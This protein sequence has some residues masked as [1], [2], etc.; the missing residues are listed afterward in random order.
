[1]CGIAGY[2]VRPDVPWRPTH[3]H[4]GKLLEDN[5]TR[6][7]DAT[8]YS[9][10]LEGS[11][12]SGKPF[13][14]SKAPIRAT[15]FVSFMDKNQTKFPIGRMGVLHTRG[16]SVGSPKNN[17][18]NHPIVY[19][20][21]DRKVMIVHNGSVGNLTEAYSKLGVE[22]FAEVDS[23]LFAAA[24]AVLGPEGGL[25]FMVKNSGGSATVAAMFNDGTFLLA[26]SMN[27]LYVAQPCD[28]AIMF[29]SVISELENLT[30]PKGMGITTRRAAEFPGGKYAIWGPGGDLV[31]SGSWNLPTMFNSPEYLKYK[32]QVVT[33]IYDY[34]PSSN[35]KSTSQKALASNSE[36]VD[37][38]HKTLGDIPKNVNITC[39]WAGCWKRSLKTISFRETYASLCKG[40]HKKTVKKGH[41]LLISN[42]GELKRKQKFDSHS[43]VVVDQFAKLH[44][45]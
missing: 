24:F 14:L 42:S 44:S 19:G 37:P 9:T 28:G 33:N 43:K 32:K 27:P 15:D 7:Y 3:N 23:A 21:G 25:E 41:N 8:G 38:V 45:S 18:N 2:F 35:F 36:V 30:D 31:G 22:Q 6:G 4:L 5:I 34:V 29:S 39:H 1:M 26:R 40:H 12:Y 11:M 17:D 10:L 13:F 16:A 20:H